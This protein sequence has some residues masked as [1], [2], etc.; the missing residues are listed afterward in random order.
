MTKVSLL[1]NSKVKIY[2]IAYSINLVPFLGSYIKTTV[3]EMGHTHNELLNREIQ[4]MDLCAYS[5]EIDI[6]KAENLIE[7]IN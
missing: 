3:D 2:K 1:G 6:F 7:I 5:N 4:L